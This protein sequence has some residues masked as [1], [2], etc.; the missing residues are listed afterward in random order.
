MDVL[1]EWVTQ[2]IIFLLLASVVD[3]LVPAT[4][5]KKYVKLVVGL[6]LILLILKPVFYLFDMDIRQALEGSMEQI[7]SE[8]DEMVQTENLMKT[9][10]SEIQASQHAYILEQMA[11]QLKDLANSSLQQ[12][13]E[14]EIIQIDLQISGDA[15]LTYE[16]L[17][18]NLDEINVTLQESQPG[19]GGVDAVEDVVIDTD[20]PSEEEVD[21]DV[22][23][24]KQL[25]QDLWDVEKEK[26]TIIG[27][28][29]SS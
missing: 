14:Q 1:I 4:S 25:L 12:E 21:L 17:D 3:L 19:E 24:I 2:I 22:E 7:E 5:M 27:E 11:V 13:Y 15:D 26:I 16:N 20:E 9:Q 10:K 8:Q 6:I 18:E 29:G 23:G 28:G